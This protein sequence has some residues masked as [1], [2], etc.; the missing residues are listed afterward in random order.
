MHNQRPWVRSPV[1]LPEFFLLLR[2]DV[3]ALFSTGKTRMVSMNHYHY[4][5]LN[6]DFYDAYNLFILMIIYVTL[7]IVQVMVV[8]TLFLGQ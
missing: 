3:S 7:L 5:N 4:L 1:V 6:D 2:P 8:V